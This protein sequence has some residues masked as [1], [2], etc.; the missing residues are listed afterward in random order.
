MF[1]LVTHCRGN[2]FNHA[3]RAFSPHSSLTTY[4][5]RIRLTHTDSKFNHAITA[6]NHCLLNN[7]FS[8]ALDHYA[9]SNV[10]TDSM[11]NNIG[12]CYVQL[13][14]YDSAKTA[15]QRALRLKSDN[16]ES[17]YNLAC[18]HYILKDTHQ[19]NE[20]FKKAHELDQAH[21]VAKN[22]YLSTLQILFKD[23]MENK[24]HAS[25][26]EKLDEM[27]KY[28]EY[29]E[30]GLTEKGRL[31]MEQSRYSDALQCF[32]EVIRVNPEYTESRKL[33]VKTLAAMSL[34]QQPLTTFRGQ[35]TSTSD[36]L[37]KANFPTVPKL[38]E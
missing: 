8:E 6:G 19:A 1:R 13:K 14:Q 27:L 9:Q 31:Y 36:V 5:P 26:H 30:Y 32:K 11:L 38:N 15:Y 12:A 20:Y 17:N 7:Q 16:F 2:L 10:V 25:A 21:Q 18:L 24:R 33:Y 35:Q 28:D 22:N 37:A 29:F 23:D 3:R 4:V 34:S